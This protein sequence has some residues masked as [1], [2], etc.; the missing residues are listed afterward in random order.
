MEDSCK[1]IDQ[2][3]TYALHDGGV[4]FELLF[5]QVKLTQLEKATL[6]DKRGY[7]TVCLFLL[8]FY[9]L[10]DIIIVSDWP[11]SRTV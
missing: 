1:K 6:L 11:E 7:L 9:S 8:R 10:Y 3:R 4:N 5:G 2:N